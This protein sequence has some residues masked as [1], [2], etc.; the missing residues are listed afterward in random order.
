LTDTA[1]YIYT[2][3]QAASRK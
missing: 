1:L 2:T 3:I